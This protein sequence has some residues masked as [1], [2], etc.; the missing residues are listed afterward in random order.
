MNNLKKYRKMF[1]LTQRD[2]A[3]SLNVTRQT[4]NA[5]ETGRH[6]PKLPLALKIAKTFNCKIEDLFE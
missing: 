3:L 4:V 6:N 5:I 1:K 2:L